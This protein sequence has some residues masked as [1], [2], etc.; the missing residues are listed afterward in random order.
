MS[1]V[2]KLPIAKM[3]DSWGRPQG[4]AAM[5]TLATAGL[6][7]MALCQNVRT[8]A[9]AEVCHHREVTREILC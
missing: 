8:Y 1:G 2:L 3:I 4:L 5:I 6:V 7:L 9:A